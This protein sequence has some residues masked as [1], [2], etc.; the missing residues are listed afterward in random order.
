VQPYRHIAGNSRVLVSIPHAGIFVPPEIAA[1]L[2]P[3]GRELPDTDWHVDR[4]YDF[5]PRL[6]VSVLVATHSRYVV[7][8]N[9]SPDGAPLYP[10]H[11]ETGVCPVE[12]FGGAPVWSAGHA[13]TPGEVAQRIGRYWRP[14]HEQV[15]E[16]VRR[17]RA[18]H[19]AVVIWDAHSIRGRLPRLFDGDLPVFNFGTNSGA[20]CDAALAN[21]L[22]HEVRGRCGHP[23]VLDGRFKGGYIT[24]AYGRPL[25]GVHSV[26]LELAQGCYMNENTGEYM[27]A[28]ARDIAQILES[29]IRITLSQQL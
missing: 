26:Q 10:G 19:G 5:L 1:R 23:V 25:D 3:Q 27:P 24:R 6:G 28:P 22:V 11:A 13:P 14:Y 17:L 18:L 21:A 9:R 8:L 15:R 12:T 29:L 16:E 2:T 4:L 7:D 20:S